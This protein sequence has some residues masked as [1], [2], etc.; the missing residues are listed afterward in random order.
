[1]KYIR[2]ACWTA[3]LPLLSV[4]KW[5]YN[6]VENEGHFKSK[7]QFLFIPVLNLCSFDF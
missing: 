1:M 5:F 2:I 4:D 6:T 7:F 3:A